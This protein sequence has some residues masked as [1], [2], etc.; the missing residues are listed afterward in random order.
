M[1]RKVN[2]K[3]LRRLVEQIVNELEKSSDIEITITKRNEDERDLKRHGQT[4][5]DVDYVYTEDDT[6]IQFSGSL[7]PY[8]TGRDYEY[9]FEPSWFHD[10][11]SEQYYNENWEDIEEEILEKFYKEKI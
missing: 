9:E 4:K 2:M 6:M 5:Y 11:E 7:N 1:N 3:E 8:H 10:K